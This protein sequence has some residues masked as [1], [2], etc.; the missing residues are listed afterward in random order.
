MIPNGLFLLNRYF[1]AYWIWQ[2]SN[3]QSLVLLT[4]C[5]G[6]LRWLK[7]SPHKWWVT[8]KEFPYYCVIKRQF[9]AVDFPIS[10]VH[11]LWQQCSTI[12]LVVNLI[13]ATWNLRIKRSC[14][15]T[16]FVTTV[17]VI[18]SVIRASKE[19]VA[20]SVKRYMKL[21]VMIAT[22]VRRRCGACV[23]LSLEVLRCDYIAWNSS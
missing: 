10:L 15:Q 14:K 16:H 9:E 3:H 19:I 2:H 21:G 1:K 22:A 13:H 23:S 20:Q 5:S 7:V 18:N 8:R 11:S 12:C 17:I 4:L 6:I